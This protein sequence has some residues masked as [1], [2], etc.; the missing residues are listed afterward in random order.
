MLSYIL[1]LQMLTLTLKEYLPEELKAAIWFYISNTGSIL[2]AILCPR[3]YLS[4]L[5]DDFKFFLG[6]NFTHL[7]KMPE[8]HNLTTTG[9][10]I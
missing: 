3:Q 7:Q 8:D 2:W 1:H 5:K 6:Y 10:K 9:K 4:D